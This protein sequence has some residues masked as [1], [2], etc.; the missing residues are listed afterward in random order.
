MPQDIS[1]KPVYQAR[2]HK[3]QSLLAAVDDYVVIDIETTGLSPSFSE[4]IELGAARV[5]G[6]RVVD[7]FETLVRPAGIISAFITGLTGITNTMAQSAPAVITALPRYL[8]FIGNSIVIG[9]NVHFDINCIYD[10]CH[11]WLNVTFPND[12]IDTMRLSRCLYKGVKGYRLSNLVQRFGIGGT[13]AHRA[14]SDVLKTQQ[15]YEYMKTRA[16]ND[17]ALKKLLCDQT[18]IAG[19][20]QLALP[21]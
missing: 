7:R 13:V 12:F 8:D 6:G 9:H 5:T 20:R 4:I 19:H 14:L 21:L 3:G 18:Q 15:C 1:V 16:L 2:P 17:A 11:R 10:H